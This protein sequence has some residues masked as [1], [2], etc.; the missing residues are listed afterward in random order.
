MDSRFQVL[1]SSICL[2]NLDSGFQMDSKCMLVLFRICYSRS[3]SPSFL[4][5]TWSWNE[6][7]AT[8]RLQIKPS[9]SFD[10]SG[11]PWAVFRILKPRIKQIFSGFYKQKFPGF[12]N[13]YS[14]TWMGRLIVYARFARYE[15]IKSP[16]PDQESTV[17]F[18]N[19][20][21]PN[22]LNLVI[23]IEAS[24]IRVHTFCPESR[25]H[26]ALNSRILA[27][28]KRQI[29]HLEKAH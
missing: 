7:L 4:L 23:P 24:R 3:Q 15:S 5:V 6:G 16:F 29:P 19:P 9:S 26:F 17:G 21:I 10:E 27:D 22:P 18:F 28:F 8:G 13:P 12:R 25:P 14:L 1:D 2:C 11:I 20:V